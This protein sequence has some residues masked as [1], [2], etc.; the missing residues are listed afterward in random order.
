MSSFACKFQALSKTLREGSA[1]GRV[2]YTQANQIRPPVFVW[3]LWNSGGMAQGLATQ[4]ALCHRQ[5]AHCH[6]QALQ[7]QRGHCAA[8]QTPRR[9]AR[10]AARHLTATAVAAVEDAPSTS[11]A[12]PEEEFVNAMDFTNTEDL[13]AR[14]NQLLEQG[15]AE[16]KQGDKVTGII[17]TCAAALLRD[18]VFACLLQ[19]C[20]VCQVSARHARTKGFSATAE[21][22]SEGP[23]WKL[24]ARC[25]L[26]AP[27]MSSACASSRGCGGRSLLACLPL[28]LLCGSADHIIV[29]LTTNSGCGCV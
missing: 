17:A 25:Q 29:L 5:S 1:R 27:L 23:M 28:L 4:M 8:W 16:H 6:N 12:A 13:Y 22:T 21:W 7:Q 24:V 19:V 2:S 14:F 11:S 20:A 10:P 26:T 3:F 18:S 15:V 9:C